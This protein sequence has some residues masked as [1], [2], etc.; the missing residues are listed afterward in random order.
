MGTGPWLEPQLTPRLSTGKRAAPEVYLFLPPEEKNGTTTVTLTCLI[1]NFFPADV[2][3]RWLQDEALIQTG[4]QA[5]TGPLK[6]GSSSP[7][8]FVFS[9]LVVS[10]ADWDRS[11]K[12]TCQ[13]VHEALPGSRTLKKSVSK[14]P[15]N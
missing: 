9:R 13:V 6:A 15:G 8:F 5:T 14:D 11:S 2:S 12:F 10:R 3:V 4:Q 1:Q 7:A